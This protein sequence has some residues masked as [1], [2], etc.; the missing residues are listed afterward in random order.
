MADRAPPVVRRVIVPP[1][2]GSPNS[3]HQFAFAIGVIV[4]GAVVV[5]A[6]D[7]VVDLGVVVLVFSLV[8]DTTIA[9]LISKAIT[10]HINLI[11]T[12]YLPHII[13]FEN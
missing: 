4:C 1:Y 12:L 6:T 3:S 5:G 7:V 11:F 13:Y 2:S 8:Q 10:D 9:R